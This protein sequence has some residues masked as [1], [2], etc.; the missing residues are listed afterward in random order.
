MP[1]TIVIELFGYYKV[2]S[3]HANELAF[4]LVVSGFGYYK[5]S[6]NHANKP[7]FKLVVSGSA[8]LFAY[9][10]TGLHRNSCI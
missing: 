6:N 3:N 7:C 4:M 5:V 10:Q 1:S 9:T 2:S 8:L